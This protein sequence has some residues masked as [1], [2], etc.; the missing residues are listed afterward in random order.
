MFLSEAPGNQAVFLGQVPAA[1]ARPGPAWT[2]P[3]GHMDAAT[4]ALS[5]PLSTVGSVQGTP[6]IVMQWLF[7]HGLPV[8]NNSDPMGYSMLNCKP[9]RSFVETHEHRA[10][11]FFSL[12]N[13]C[14]SSYL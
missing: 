1:A 5:T 12:V 13:V 7:V 11:W 4:L 2:G 9:V 3:G 8:F 14:Q 10:T 6:D